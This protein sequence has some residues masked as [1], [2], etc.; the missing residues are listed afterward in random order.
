MSEKRRQAYNALADA[1]QN[2]VDVA[3][4]PS[5]SVISDFVVIVATS[6][7]NEETG[8]IDHDIALLD[9]DNNQPVHRTVGLLDRAEILVDG[10][11]D[12]GD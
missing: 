3:D 9:R 7:L 4:C 12:S 10:W 6:R 2:T 1:I 5:G 8:D 11:T